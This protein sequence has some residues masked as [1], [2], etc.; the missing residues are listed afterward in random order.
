MR[1]LA[2]EFRVSDVAIAKACRRANIPIPGR[3]HW[4][5]IKAGK[6]VSITPLPPRSFGMNLDVTFGAG[7]YGHQRP[8]TDEEFLEEHT[9]PPLFEESVTDLLLKAQKVIKKVAYKRD[10]TK[11]HPLPMPLRRFMFPLCSDSGVGVNRTY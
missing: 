2:Q 7:R 11:V 6:S 8:L 4:A 1:Q 3:G 10:L 5:K 9:P